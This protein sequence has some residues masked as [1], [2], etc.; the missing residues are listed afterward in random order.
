MKSLMVFAKHPGIDGLFPKGIVSKDAYEVTGAIFLQ[1]ALRELFSCKA[2]Y[3][4]TA[5]I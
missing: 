1:S 5:N 2:R 4:P 3:S